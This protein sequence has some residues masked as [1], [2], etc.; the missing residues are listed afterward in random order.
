[1]VKVPPATFRTGEG[2]AGDL[3]DR[4]LQVRGAEPE[5]R[6]G[7]FHL[8]EAEAGQDVPG[9]H[10]AHV[11]VA[12]EAFHVVEVHFLIDLA[13][14]VRGLVG[15][16]Q[17]GIQVDGVVPGLVAVGVLADE[18][19]DVRGG[20]L[21]L[22]VVRRLEEAVQLR[23]HRLPGAEQVLEALDVLRRMNCRSGSQKWR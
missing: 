19:G 23:E 18:A 12:G 7:R 4:L 20:V 6:A 13:E 22:H 8:V 11:L 17:H 2:A 10:L 15:F 1:M 5:A 21:A 14:P 9:A 16:A 3:Q